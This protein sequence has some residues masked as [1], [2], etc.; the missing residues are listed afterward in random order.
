VLAKALIIPAILIKSSFCN[1]NKIWTDSMLTEAAA[2]RHASTKTV[3]N[4]S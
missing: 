4:G 3:E 2:D 1:K